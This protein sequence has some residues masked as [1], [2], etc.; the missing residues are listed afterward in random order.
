MANAIV[1]H[2]H[3]CKECGTWMKRDHQTILHH[4]NEAHKNN[5][6]GMFIC[7]ICIK[8]FS[9]FWTLSRHTRT[10]HN[11]ILQDSA[12]FL[13]TLIPNQK[14]TKASRLWPTHYKP[15]SVT[16]RIFYGNNSPYPSC[17]Q[18]SVFHRPRIVTL[19]PLVQTSHT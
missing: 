3:F 5:G 2:L 12:S 14:T 4:L 8:P 18:P 1:A 13:P 10:I 6:K 15:P 7:P 11:V 9:R 17:L 19:D 16:L